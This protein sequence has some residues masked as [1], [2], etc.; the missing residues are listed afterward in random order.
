MAKVKKNFSFTK[1]CFEDSL[2]K[3]MELKPYNKISIQD[4]T[5]V[6]GFTRMT[7]YRNFKSI[8]QVLAYSLNK[9]RSYLAKEFSKID[10]GANQKDDI[11]FIFNLLYEIKD[12]S[13]ILLKNGLSSYLKNEF[14]SCI[15]K[16]SLITKGNQY[17]FLFISGGL[18]NVYQ[19]WLLSGCK[20]TPKEMSQLILKEIQIYRRGRTYSNL[21]KKTIN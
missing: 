14:D 17:Q 1:D 12:Y 10:F 19:Q 11:E 15:S 18:F 21:K 16:L 3:M 6:S 9:R 5:K 4:I 8:D 20:E 7:F 2:F 13:M